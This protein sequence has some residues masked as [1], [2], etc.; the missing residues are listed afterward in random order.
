MNTA[1]AWFRARAPR[2]RLALT[3]GA[4]AVLLLVLYGWIWLPL[5][6]DTARLRASLPALRKDAAHLAAS[7]EEAK[8]LAAA[9]HTQVAGE[10]LATAVEQSITG[11]GLKDRV[12]MLPLDGNRVQLNSE[13]IGFNDW[14]I[15]VSTLQQS[16]HAKV[17][18]A[19]IEPQPGSSL[20]RVQ[21]VVAR[22][23]A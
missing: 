23:A 7:A 18:S 5:S 17:E 20:V 8:R 11:M 2:E 3:A 6:A 1:L 13:G 19:R 12:Q 4:A 15:L 9:P 14:V 21:A 10:A 16:R 22:Q